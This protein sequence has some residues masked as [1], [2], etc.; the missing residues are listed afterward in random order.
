MSRRR[1][2][3]GGIYFPEILAILALMGL[4]LA[5]AAPSA[6]RVI[7]RELGEITASQIVSEIRLHRSETVASGVGRAMVF[8]RRSDAEWTIT[9]VL[10]GDGDGVRADDRRRGIDRIV[11]GPQ[12]VTDRFGGAR[13]GFHPSL[14]Q[15]RSP[16]PTSA[17]LGDLDDPVRLGLGD[18]ISFNP[19][20]TITSGTIYLTDGSERQLAV[21]LYGQT[22]RLR[23]WEYDLSLGRWKARF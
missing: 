7:A 1:P 17:P 3:Q 14:T 16:P 10:D 15:L 19:R 5:G 20:G 22:A 6:R 4:A 9:V 8:A 18:V 23:L 21:V 12:A 13:L 11:D 2:R